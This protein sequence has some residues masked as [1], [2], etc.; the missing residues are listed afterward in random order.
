MKKIY[1]SHSRY[2][3]FKKELYEPIRSSELNNKY[4]F[5]L[6]HEESEGLFDSRSLFIN[7]GCDLVLADVSFPAT[8]VGIELGWA[9]ISNIRVICIHKK[10]SKLASSL[11]IITKDFIEYENTQD[12]ISKLITLLN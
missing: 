6:P 4:I 1:V 3:D 12:L 11:Q 2:F 9:N 8:G 7:K 5:I 10:D